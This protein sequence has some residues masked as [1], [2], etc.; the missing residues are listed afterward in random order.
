MGRKL[1]QR[2]KVTYI[3]MILSN[4]FK[5]QRWLN[6]YKV[7]QGDVVKRS[8]AGK[9]AIANIVH[10][11]RSET[12]LYLVLSNAGREGDNAIIPAKKTKK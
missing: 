9:S 1:P 2:L 10:L 4:R 7:E 6:T 12:L 11:S 8:I 5:T 3:A